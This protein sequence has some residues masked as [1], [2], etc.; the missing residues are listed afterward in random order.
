MPFGVFSSYLFHHLVKEKAIS[1]HSTSDEQNLVRQTSICRSRRLS[2]PF[3]GAVLNLTSKQPDTIHE[4]KI[5]QWFLEPQFWLIALHFT[6]TRLIIQTSQLYI[7]FFVIQT[8][9]LPNKYMAIIPL[10]MYSAGLLISGL[11]KYLGD[12]VGLKPSLGFFSI[13]GLVGCLWISFGCNNQAYYIYEV[14]GIAILIGG[15]S[16]GM[17]ILSSTMIAACIG[18]NTGKRQRV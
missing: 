7:P 11:T 17:L 1:S 15:A 3:K 12:I 10:I 18:S 8:L 9:K 5:W 14:V 2:A 16:S 4:M 6:E 13:F